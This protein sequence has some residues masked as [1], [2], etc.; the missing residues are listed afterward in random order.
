MAEQLTPGEIWHGMHEKGD[1]AGASDAA[2]AVLAAIDTQNFTDLTVSKD[3]GEYAR[4][5]MVTAMSAVKKSSDWGSARVFLRRAVSVAAGHYPIGFTEEIAEIKG[6][7][8]EGVSGEESAQLQCLRD[9]L[10]LS[11]LLIILYP[12]QEMY[13]WLVDVEDVLTRAA[14]GSTERHALIFVMENGGYEAAVAAYTTY[15]ELHGSPQSELYSPE[16][17]AVVQTRM[18][19][20]SLDVGDFKNVSRL[21]FQL[22]KT[23]LSKPDLKK[24]IFVQLVRNHSSV[25]KTKL[26]ERK[27]RK[28][29]DSATNDREL[30]EEI[31][32]LINNKYTWLGSDA[33]SQTTDHSA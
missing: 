12:T 15:L 6:K 28:W 32:V 14:E 11:Q 4:I 19:G 21:Y 2:A 9:V 18:I 7:Y 1:S 13:D 31:F 5:A 23:A 10:H 29:V 22:T 8:W 20:R 17:I 27:L 24:F 25:F 33:D 3:H 16:E 26:I 30:L